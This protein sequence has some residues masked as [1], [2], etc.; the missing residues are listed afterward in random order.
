MAVAELLVA[1]RAGVN[2]QNQEGWT[3]LHEAARESNGTLAEFLLRHGAD[4]NIVDKTGQTPAAI[5]MGERHRE[6]V[7]LLVN[8]GSPVTIHLASWL[9]RHERVKGLIESGVDVNARDRFDRTP[10]YLA[11]GMGHAEVAALLFDS[12]ADVNARAY[13]LGYTPLRSCA[14]DPGAALR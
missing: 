10:L 12:G 2:L 5:A 1:R 6:V 7:E 13:V 3:P 4:P 9:G 14:I 8:A 11:A